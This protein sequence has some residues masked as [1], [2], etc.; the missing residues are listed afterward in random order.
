[1]KELIFFYIKEFSIT[2]NDFN[3]SFS[4]VKNNDEISIVIDLDKASQKIKEQLNHIEKKIK[5]EFNT[6]EIKISII[7]TG[8]KQKTPK[9]IIAVA[10]G[11]GGVGKSTTALNL[12]YALKQL[13]FNVGLLDTDIYGPSLPIMLGIDQ[14]PEVD[15]NLK[16]LIPIKHLG[17]EVMSI[18]F[19]IPEENPVIWRGLMVQ[20]AI[21]QLL[22]DVAWGAKSPL[23]YLILDLPPGTGDVPLTIIQT[24]ELSAAIIVSTPQ[25]LALAD[26]KRAV[27]MFKKTNTPILGIVD[28]MH[29]LTC[30]HCD[31]KIDVFGSNKTKQYASSTNIEILEEM[32]LSLDI[33]KTTEQQTP[34]VLENALAIETKK[35]INIAK[36]TEDFFNAL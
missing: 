28:N 33:K 20:K 6:K 7:T 16:K 14:K 9:Y 35:Y 24:I 22:S 3:Q 17:V 26:A 11:K 15:E 10:S 27:G 12:S 25:D 19:M 13:G 30:P 1:M 8:K 2:E 32:P 18:G 31:N 29:Q 36:K 23:D 21:K 5:E 4:I 34:I